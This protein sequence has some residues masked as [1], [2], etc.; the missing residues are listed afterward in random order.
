[1][2]GSFA[3][4]LRAR[5]IRSRGARH[6]RRSSRTR[7]PPRKHRWPPSSQYPRTPPRLRNRRRLPSSASYP[8]TPPRLK[9]AQEAAELAVPEDA[10][11]LGELA[12]PEGD[13]VEDLQ[14]GEPEFVIAAAALDES[15]EASREDKPGLEPDEDGPWLTGSAAGKLSVTDE[16]EP[17]HEREPQAPAA[18]FDGGAKAGI[19]PTERPGPQPGI[20]VL[21]PE[22]MVDM[23]PEV[24]DALLAAVFGEASARLLEPKALTV[25]AL[26]NEEFAPSDRGTAPPMTP[27]VPPTAI[28]ADLPPPLRS[29]FPPRLRFRY[30]RHQ[31]SAAPTSETGR[32]RTRTTCT[33]LR[34]GR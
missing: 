26:L 21:D 28:E 18:A 11:E 2:R 14:A 19:R 25:E 32:H 5:G 23:S 4:Y 27:L 10:R 30:L 29:R 34:R 8:R 15:V 6:A 20:R 24:L 12:T 16:A 7:A 22:R 13:M 33:P 31:Q 1:M 3:G 9:D 17:R